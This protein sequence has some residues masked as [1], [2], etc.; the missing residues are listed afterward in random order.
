MFTGI[1]EHRGEI[2]ERRRVPEGITFVV[3]AAGL[4]NMLEPGDSISINGACHTVESSRE[5][6]F[7]FLRSSPPRLWGAMDGPR[8]ASAS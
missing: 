2:V 7:P 3:G 1:I 8:R 5:Q 6:R 4:A